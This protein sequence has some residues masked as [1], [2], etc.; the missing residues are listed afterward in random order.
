[1]LPG[2]KIEPDETPAAA[3]CRE[4]RE[5]TGS[6]LAEKALAALGT[7]TAPAAHEPGI[8]IQAHVFTGGVVDP[9]RVSARAEIE[10]LGWLARGHE[11]AMPLAPLLDRFVLPALGWTPTR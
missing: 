7:F 3:A 8:T 5:E 9:D 6:T 10:S 4:V 11:Q 1:M 2:G